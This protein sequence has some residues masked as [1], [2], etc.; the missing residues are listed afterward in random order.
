M[1]S[2]NQ[3]NLGHYTVQSSHKKWV[4]PPVCVCVCLC[5]CVC[6]CAHILDDGYIGNTSGYNFILIFNKICNLIFFVLSRDRSA[7]S[8]CGIVVSRVV[9]R[10]CSLLARNIIR[11]KG[12]I[13]WDQWGAYRATT[14]HSVAGKNGRSFRVPGLSEILV[15]RTD[16]CR[17][18]S[19]CIL[20][21]SLLHLCCRKRVL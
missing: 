18:L 5:V 10:E 21:G 16:R 3:I 12:M 17:N 20:F 4:Q 1:R 8:G 14:D 15:H 7:N 2:G 11:S 9:A 19:F 6:V 13:R